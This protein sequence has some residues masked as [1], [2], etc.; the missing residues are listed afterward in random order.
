MPYA[1]V[2]SGQTRFCK[3]YINGVEDTTLGNSNSKT[4]TDKTFN[5]NGLF[6]S[7]FDFSEPTCYMDEVRIY[8]FALT[9]EQ[10]TVIYDQYATSGV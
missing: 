2:A 3:L 4:L 1:T 6:W 9:P 8:D 10:I 5:N 7:A